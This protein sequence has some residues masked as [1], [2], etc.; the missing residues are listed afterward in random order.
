MLFSHYGRVHV[1]R[2]S[3]ID[4]HRAAPLEVT[5]EARE[6]LTP[7]RERTFRAMYDAAMA[8]GG[9]DVVA[10]AQ[11]I[12]R[13]LLHDEDMDSFVFVCWVDGS[14]DDAQS[15]RQRV[16]ACLSDLHPSW[17]D[18]ERA[19]HARMIY[20]SAPVLPGHLRRATA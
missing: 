11:V 2:A 15:A 12:F 17:T 14:R 20:F 16:L 18:A 19:D 4:Q 10:S 8:D 6:R 3:A 9:A 1:A 5:P 7:F 13:E